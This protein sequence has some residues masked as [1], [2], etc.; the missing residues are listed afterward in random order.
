MEDNKKALENESVNTF[1]TSIIQ[2]NSGFV[3]LFK[4]FLY[5]EWYTN[6]NT[7]RVFIH[8][9]LKANYKSKKWQGKVIPAGSFITGRRKM[10]QE[11]AM[12]EQQVR[13]ALSNLK[14]TNEI[15]IK[16]YSQ[17]SIISIN[18]WDKFQG[19]NQQSN[20]QITNEQPTDNQQIT[21]T[22]NIKNIKKNIYRGTK[23]FQVPTL[24]EVQE[25]INE[26]GS[27]VDANT[28][29]DYYTANGWK[30]NKNPLKDWQAALR[31]WDRR[32]KKLSQPKQEVK[33]Y[34]YNPYL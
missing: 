24:T 8:C 30:I 26:I 20:Q 7:M 5:W 2:Q 27:S 1:N 11:L 17:Y 22:K 25:Y 15:T 14:S 9:L 34:V 31:G 28:F 29:I 6:A 32:N 4:I 19:I 12:T 21:T 33:E 18:N 10:A 13:T 16:P 3:K 23:K